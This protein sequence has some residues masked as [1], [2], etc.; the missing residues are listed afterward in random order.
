VAP[1]AFITQGSV[2]GVPPQLKLTSHGAAVVVVGAAVV[3][4]GPAVVV[5]G[6]TVVVVGGQV[7]EINVML[8]PAQSS[9]QGVALPNDE[10]HSGN[11]AP[12]EPPISHREPFQ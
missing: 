12:S 1:S 5:V 2:V 6:A 9:P 7:P 3:V 4:V 10:V 8:Q 11:P